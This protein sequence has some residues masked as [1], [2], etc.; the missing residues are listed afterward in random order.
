MQKKLFIVV[1]QD[2]FFLHN[3]DPGRIFFHDFSEKGCGLF[4]KQKIH[5]N[6]KST[7]LLVANVLKWRNCNL[8]VI[9]NPRRT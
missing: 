4:S 1:N 3:E 9:E 2:F 6:G 5:K 7:Y 8:C